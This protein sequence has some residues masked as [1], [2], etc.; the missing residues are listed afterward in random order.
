MRIDS[1]TTGQMAGIADI[2]AQNNLEN[3]K[4]A[5]GLLGED[6][7]VV[8]FSKESKDLAEQ[9]KG[10]KAGNVPA[11]TDASK[12]KS[13]DNPRASDNTASMGAAGGGQSPAGGVMAGASG[14]G[15]GGSEGEEDEDENKKERERIEKEIANLESEL[16]GLESSDSSDEEKATSA[17]NLRAQISAL[18][19]QKSALT[20]VEQA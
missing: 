18:E 14:I 1:S 16:A 8:A 2:N 12:I 19:A 4:A 15:G 13:V 20:E 6:G 11:N 17:S 10:Q 9:L 5:L 7:D 3:K